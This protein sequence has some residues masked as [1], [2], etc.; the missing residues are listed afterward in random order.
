MGR[1]LDL[2]FPALALASGLAMLS[3]RSGFAQI[4]PPPNQGLVVRDGTLGSLP[5]GV[6][7]RGP[8][9][10]GTADY[11][12][13]ADLGEQRGGN[14]FHSFEKFSIGHGERATFTSDGA[15]DPGAIDNVISRVTGPDPS[16]IDGTLHSTIPG[17]DVWLL[18][19]SGIMFGEGAKLDVPASFHASTGDY[20]SFKG[21]LERFYADG[22]PSSVLS[23]APPEAFGFLGEQ[24]AQPISVTGTTL[25]VPD[26]KSFE[27][28]G[29]DVTLTGATLDAPAGAVSIRGGPIAV[30]EGSKVLA[31]NSDDQ[32]AG[33][34]S[35]AASE[36]VLV[37]DSLLSVSTHAAGDAGTIHVESPSVTF[38]NGPQAP[39]HPVHT[40]PDHGEYG[41]P[42]FETEVGASAETFGSGVGGTIQIDADALTLE[43]NVMVSAGAGIGTK[44]DA[45]KIRIHGAKW[46]LSAGSAIAAGTYGTG[47]AGTVSIALSDTLRL[48]GTSTNE[49]P[50]YVFTAADGLEG[51]ARAPGRI[52]I[53]AGAIEL[54]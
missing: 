41:L 34:I 54:V 24:A 18:N 15:P 21:G 51:S 43:K 33:A 22:R 50:P 52:E 23:T 42:P 31:E 32:P 44:G 14:L 49:I 2:R 37:D 53:E 20:V 48:D 25:N 1:S 47:N 46:K 8:D 4:P 27:L 11:L 40:Y 3:A 10:L 35:V 16:Q 26:G 6:V 29:G 9:D 7:S 28:T 12:I 5:A 19:P 45:G 38:Q 39:L 36:S 17:A 13:R 30:E